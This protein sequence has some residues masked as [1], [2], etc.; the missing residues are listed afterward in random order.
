MFIFLFQSVMTVER[1]TCIIIIIIIIISFMQGI[2]T[3]ISETNYVSREYAF[4][5]ILLLLFMVLISLFPV[6]NLLFYLLLLLLL[7]LSLLLIRTI[8]Y[9]FSTLDSLLILY[10]TLVRLK[11]ESTSTL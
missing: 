10:L 5:A 4:A 2:Y 1:D 9:S 3:Y 8:T 7:I 11:F 6:L